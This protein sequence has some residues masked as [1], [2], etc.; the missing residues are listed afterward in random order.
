MHLRLP[1]LG[2]LCAERVALPAPDDALIR[3]L[4]A[5][6]NLALLDSAAGGRYTV[7]AA[8]RWARPAS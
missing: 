6:P 8:G 3:R 5:L 7:A 2:R 4:H 1:D